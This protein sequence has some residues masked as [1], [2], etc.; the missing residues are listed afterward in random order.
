MR[1]LNALQWLRERN[2]GLRFESNGTVSAW[3]RVTRTIR[4]RRA[5][6]TAAIGALRAATD[7][8]A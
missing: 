5:D 7:G 3:V 2:G 6:I 8:T 1:Q 4:R